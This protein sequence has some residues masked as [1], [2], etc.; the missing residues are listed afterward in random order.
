MVVL[1]VK[2]NT[3]PYQKLEALQVYLIVVQD[4]LQVTMFYRDLAGAWE[5]T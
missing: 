2:Q 4:Q 1:V 5:V 3:Y